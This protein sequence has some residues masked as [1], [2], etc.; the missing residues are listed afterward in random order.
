VPLLEATRAVAEGRVKLNGAPYTWE[1]EPMV[2]WR[3]PSAHADDA[4]AIAAA[5]ES[6]HF[7]LESVQQ[8]AGG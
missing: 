5:R 2:Q 4:P 8:P 7:T 3:D 6:S 1:A